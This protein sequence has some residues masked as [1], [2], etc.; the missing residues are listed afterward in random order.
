VSEL[1]GDAQSRGALVQP[2]D[3]PSKARAISFEPTIPDNVDDGTSHRRRDAVRTRAPDHSLFRIDEV[4][5]RANATHLV[6]VPP[7]DE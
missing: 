5:K 6:S 1:V 3:T 2:E 7:F 4:L